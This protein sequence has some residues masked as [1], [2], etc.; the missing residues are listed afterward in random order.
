MMKELALQVINE[1][2]DNVDMVDII[3]MLY[4]RM[5]VQEGLNDVEAGNT[6]SQEELEKEI[7]TW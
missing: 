7:E 1:L 3:E 5:K 2:P 6:I 4:I